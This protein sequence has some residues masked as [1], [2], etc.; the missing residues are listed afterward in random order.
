MAFQGVLGAA[1][2]GTRGECRRQMI[3]AGVG[4]GALSQG[5]VLLS[6]FLL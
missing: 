4:R 5:L 6:L 1:G 3:V 2:T